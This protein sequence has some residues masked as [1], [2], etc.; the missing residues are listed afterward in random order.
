MK[1]TKTR[2]GAAWRLLIDGRRCALTIHKGEAP[3]YREPQEYHLIH[4]ED[5]RYLFSAKSVGG[6]IGLLEFIAAEF[7]PPESTR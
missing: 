7:Q 4:D 3:R 6:L 5:D 1:I 2:E